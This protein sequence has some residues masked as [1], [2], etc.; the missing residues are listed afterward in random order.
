M[1]QHPTRLLQPTNV[2]EQ[3]AEIDERHIVVWII[4]QRP[5]IEALGLVG[6]PRPRQHIR[7]IHQ[8]AHIIRRP[9]EVATEES[10]GARRIHLH[11]PRI[12]LHRLVLPPATFEQTRQLHVRGRF[13]RRQRHRLAQRRFGLAPALVAHQHERVIQVGGGGV[14]RKDECPLVRGL[15]LLHPIKLFEHSSQR[16]VDASLLRSERHRSAQHDHRVTRFAPPRQ[17]Q[18]V[19]QMRGRLPGCQVHRPPQQRLRLIGQTAPLQQRTQ[20]QG[21]GR[22]PRLQ[23][24][25]LAIECLRLVCPARALAQ[26]RE[27]RRH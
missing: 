19:F 23:H 10:L 5:A 15:G 25:R 22:V 17:M 8:C 14:W 24:H 20:L 27:L 1:R 16:A 6:S 2:L 18:T 21:E 26:L 7:Q 12:E 9:R 11:R 3:Q 4:L 13:L